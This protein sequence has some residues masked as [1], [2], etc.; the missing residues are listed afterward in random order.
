[1][2]RA[3]ALGF[4]A[5]ENAAS[6]DIASPAVRRIGNAFH[7]QMKCSPEG[8]R[9][10]AYR[11]SAPAHRSGA[12]VQGCSPGNPVLTEDVPSYDASGDVVGFDRT[13]YIGVFSVSE[14]EYDEVGG[15]RLNLGP[16]RYHLK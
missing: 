5:T 1:M 11:I 8:R 4:A 6:R 14:V 12:G 10:W 3:P 9:T 2:G 7:S 16:R 13:R 15:L